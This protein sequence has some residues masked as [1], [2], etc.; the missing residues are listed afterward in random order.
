MSEAQT[1]SGTCFESIHHLCK[2]AKAI[3]PDCKSTLEFQPTLGKGKGM[4]GVAKYERRIVGV[5]NPVYICKQPFSGIRA[6]NCAQLITPKVLINDSCAQSPFCMF[7]Y[8]LKMAEE[9]LG[10]W[11]GY[12]WKR[13]IFFLRY[14]WF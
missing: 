6:E 1:P 10:V 8:C 9:I 12:G 13:G 7:N 14:H 5:G 11:T 3:F 4:G 2:L